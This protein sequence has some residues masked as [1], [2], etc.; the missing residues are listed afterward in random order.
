[1][2]ISIAKRYI[3]STICTYVFIYIINNPGVADTT[4]LQDLV[5]NLLLVY[6]NGIHSM[7]RKQEFIG[8]TSNRSVL[9]ERSSGSSSN[10]ATLTA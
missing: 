3:T 6:S 9:M 4:E 2:G 8:I 1:M 7:S 5:N 10:V